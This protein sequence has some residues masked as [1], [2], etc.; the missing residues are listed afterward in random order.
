MKSLELDWTQSLRKSPLHIDLAG[1]VPPVCLIVPSAASV[2]MLGELRWKNLWFG[3]H[4]GTDGAVSLQ[5]SIKYLVSSEKLIQRHS[6]AHAVTKTG[7]KAN[8]PLSGWVLLW[9]LYILGLGKLPDRKG[10]RQRNT[11]KA[12]ITHFPGLGYQQR[13]ESLS[14]LYKL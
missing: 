2:L 6:Q 9:R 12:R 4:F 11:A 5:V 13:N 1:K 3:K 14:L 10:M 8:W 7:G